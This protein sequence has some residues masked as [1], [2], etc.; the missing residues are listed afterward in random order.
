[1]YYVNPLKLEHVYIF[2]YIYQFPSSILLLKL[3]DDQPLSYLS[4]MRQTSIVF[5]NLVLDES[6]DAEALLQ[7]IFELVY[8][9][10]KSMQGQY[11]LYLYIEYLT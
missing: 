1:M 10:T 6:Q 9:L 7:S 5:M 4:E 2:I 3:D 8:S 11:K